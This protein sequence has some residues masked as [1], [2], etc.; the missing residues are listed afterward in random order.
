MHLHCSPCNIHY[1]YILKLET[2]QEDLKYLFKQIEIQH[3]SHGIKEHSTNN[4]TQSDYEKS[5]NYFRNVSSDTLL[6]VYEFIQFD[7]ILFDYNLPDFIE[8]RIKER[9][10]IT[11]Y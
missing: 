9:I 5:F 10:N 11:T 6:D 4:K 3:L 2:F 7:V 1:D 8:N